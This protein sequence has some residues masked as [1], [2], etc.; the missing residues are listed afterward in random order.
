MART[1]R[2]EFVSLESHERRKAAVEKVFEE[3]MAEIFPNL[4]RH[5]CMDSRNSENP[6][7]GKL[8]KKS[9]P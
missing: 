8:R 4:V 3:S 2:S 6:K 5:K 1:K 9:C 7:Q